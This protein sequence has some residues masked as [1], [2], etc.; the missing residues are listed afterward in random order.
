MAKLSVRVA[1]GI[2]FLAWSGLAEEI[3][4]LTARYKEI[5]VIAGEDATAFI[6]LVTSELPKDAIGMTVSFNTDA[7]DIIAPVVP[8]NI[9]LVDGSSSSFKLF[10]L[11]PGVVSLVVNATRAFTKGP[12][13]RRFIIRKAAV[14]KCCTP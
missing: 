12:G 4:S 11:R 8:R 5:S 1:F 10:G 3:W 13:C 6:D 14:V 2:A 9:S 7:V